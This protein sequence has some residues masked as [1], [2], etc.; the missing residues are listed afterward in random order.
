[1]T[2]ALSLVDV[3]CRLAGPLNFVM[4]LRAELSR[5]GITAA[6]R[7]H[8]DAALFDWL[9]SMVSFQGIADRVADQYMRD[10]GNITWADIK[11]DLAQRPS[12]PKLGGYL[13][14]KDCRY[15]KGSGLCSEPSHLSRCPLPRHELRNGRLNQTAYS[16]FLFMRDVAERDLVHWIDGQ[17][18]GADRPPGLGDLA[19][20]RDALVQPLRGVYGI[21][22]KVITMALSMLMLG[23]GARK[24]HWTEVGASFVV[25]DTLVHNFLHRTGILR[26]IRADHPYGAACYRPN[27]CAE[28]ISRIAQQIDARAFNPSFPR[29]FPRFVQLAIW[30]YCSESGLDTCNGN[31]ITDT[32]RCD[33]AYCRLQS[34]CERVV[35]HKAL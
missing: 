16:L 15:Q 22:D 13:V 5:R 3:V 7:N 6:V 26:R 35:L 27:D 1:M 17:L 11:R 25:I 18:T 12:C 4:E 29:V 19:N 2:H 31:R 34:R 24:R 30:R 23:A 10:H 21:S 33:N 32:G 8:D 20:A 9:M 14:F 28:L